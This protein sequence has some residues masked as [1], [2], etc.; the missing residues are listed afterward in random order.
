[1]THHDDIF[2][3]FGLCPVANIWN[4]NPVFVY[5]RLQYYQWCML[6]WVCL[7]STLTKDD[8]A[9]FWIR[10][11]FN[12]HAYSI[13]I[14]SWAS[15]ETMLVKVPHI[16]MAL[17]YAFLLKKSSCN[18][19]WCV[20]IKHICVYERESVYRYSGTFKQNNGDRQVIWI[21]VPLHLKILDMQ[22]AISLP[23]HS[24]FSLSS[25]KILWILSQPNNFRTVGAQGSSTVLYF[26]TYKLMRNA[27][28]FI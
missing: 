7:R 9:P 1:M 24:C 17:W 4:K 21:F 6:F 25:H 19:N 13:V 20:C 12:F 16:K 14:Q 10:R 26:Y 8:W 27:I 11:H 5:R 22:P 18:S 15:A 2:L 3:L 23:S 28:F